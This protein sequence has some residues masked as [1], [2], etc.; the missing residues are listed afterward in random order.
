MIPRINSINELKKIFQ[1]IKTPIFYVTNNVDKGVGLEKII[2]NYH[3]VC[4]DYDD[5][6][7]YLIEK[8]VKVFCLEKEMGRKNIIFR[9]SA[10]LL[11]HRLVKKYI[12]KNSSDNFPPAIILFKPTFAAEKIARINQWTILNNPAGLSRELENKL[13]FLAIAKAAKVKTP[14]ADTFDLRRVSFYELKKYYDHFVVQ[15]GG[16]F[17]GNATFFIK[18]IAEYAKFFSNSLAKAANK[19]PVLVKVSKFIKGTPVTINACITAHE[20]IIGKPCYQ[21]T[22]VK[23]CTNNSGTTCGNDWGSLAISSEALKEIENIAEKIGKYMKGRN[24][25]GIFGLDFVVGG[26]NKNVYL[27]EINPRMVASL[28]FYTKSE[29]KSGQIPMLAFHILEFLGIDYNPP[30]DLVQL[31]SPQVARCRQPIIYNSRS[32][33]GAQLVI[34]NKENT[35]CSVGGN[36]KSGVYLFKGNALIFTRKGYSIEDLRNAGEFVVLADA[37]GRVVGSES[38]CARVES[39]LPLTDSSG[40]PY[41]KT[42]FLAKEIYKRLKLKPL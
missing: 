1:G 18:N 34:R 31:R 42:K 35:R 19:D 33:S 30:L 9:S 6:V 10:L 3:I 13:N 12:K 2:P 41:K 16:G 27:I 8:G 15:F 14:V 11:N 7:D 21:I 40:E 32:I 36:L 24:Y 26:E 22:G 20:I 38:E 5:E 23:E 25:K 39:L 17:A 4:I 28:P 29:I 37:S